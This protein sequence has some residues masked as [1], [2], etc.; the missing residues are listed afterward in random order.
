[1]LYDLFGTFTMIYVCIVF[2]RQQA[3]TM[4]TTRSYSNSSSILFKKISN[5]CSCEQTVHRLV[6]KIDTHS[7]IPPPI[8]ASIAKYSLMEE[9]TADNLTIH[10]T[11]TTSDPPDTATTVL[12]SDNY[13]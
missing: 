4:A 8:S 6:G 9:A 1:M 5:Y 13:S 2:I 11:L 3:T 12:V 10:N 7:N